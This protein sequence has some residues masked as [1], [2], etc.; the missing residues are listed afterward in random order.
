MIKQTKLVKLLISPTK[1]IACNKLCLT[2]KQ[3]LRFTK[4][5]ESVCSS[6][7]FDRRYRP[8]RFRRALIPSLRLT[9]TT[10][11][12]IPTNNKFHAALRYRFCALRLIRRSLSLSN[13]GGISGHVFFSVILRVLSKIIACIMECVREECN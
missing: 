8:I 1:L 9:N 5:N 3:S 10:R 11:L 12:P 13:T 6:T 7:A 4:I 2:E